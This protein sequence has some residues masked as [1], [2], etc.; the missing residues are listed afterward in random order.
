MKIN[1]FGQALGKK[2]S[3]FTLENDVISLSVINFGARIHELK[4]KTGSN[5]VDVVLGCKNIDGYVNDTIFLGAT[6][7]RFANRIGGAAFSINGKKYQLDKSE[8]E[9][10]LH[11]GLTG[12]HNVVWDS[13]V[14]DDNKVRFSYV[15]KDGESGFPGNLK[16]H[17]YYSISPA[18]EVII[19]FEAETDITTV[20]NMTNHAYFNL[21][22]EASGNILD[23]KIQINSDFITEVDSA[24]IPTGKILPVDSI[25][26]FKKAG[27]IKDRFT[28][29]FD[30]FDANYVASGNINKCSAEVEGE[31]TGIKL[32]VYSDQP[33]IQFYSGKFVN[34][35]AGKS[36]TSHKAFDGFCLEPQNYPDAPN[37]ADFPSSVLNPGE[38]YQK[39]IIF[40]LQK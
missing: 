29:G 39:R 14:I 38:K 37:H 19:D 30:N 28:S 40:A 11:G 6:I 2:I 34:V 33:G 17:T 22:G 16:V 8:G 25:Y 5:D 1:D 7:G 10:T 32:R 36:G 4:V 31:K 12:F 24:L 23:H 20:V 9:N 27:V 15:S 26:D 3:C 13:E 21:N 35:P 18:G